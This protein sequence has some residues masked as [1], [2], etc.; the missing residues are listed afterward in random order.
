M[1]DSGNNIWL[2]WLLMACLAVS[3]RKD[4][5][6]ENPCAHAIVPDAG[7]EFEHGY[8]GSDGITF[9][10]DLTNDTIAEST[11]LQF[12][13]P[14]SD[15]AI[16]EHTWYI[17]SEIL[18]GY[19]EWKDFKLQPRPSDYTI[20]HTMKWNPDKLCN[21]HDDGFDSAVFRFHIAAYY[22]EFFVIGK[23]RA[24]FVDSVG[25]DSFDLDIYF[26]KLNYK[27][28]LITNPKIPGTSDD[29]IDLRIKGM[30]F[31][32]SYDS[33][34]NGISNGDFILTNRELV[35][36]GS[37]AG[38]ITPE[39][40]YVRVDP[41]TRQMEGGFYILKSGTSEPRLYQVKGYKLN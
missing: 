38:E 8:R 1:T 12:R 9:F 18:H 39:N 3:C 21:P 33:N 32:Q 37:R 4:D 15:T 35:L 28:S 25:A 16:Y 23:Y 41:Q 13:S 7:F 17:G 14:F 22:N 26:S 34:T 5:A 19:K 10:N 36:I 24:I 40:G 6:P 31:Y 30:N 2:L 20:I 29:P 11:L 27:D